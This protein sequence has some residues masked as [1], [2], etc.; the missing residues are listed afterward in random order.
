MGSFK[1][2]SKFR[3]VAEV[4]NMCIPNEKL[5]LLLNR[6]IQKLHLRNVRLFSEE[7]EEQ[8]KRYVFN[9]E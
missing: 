4:V 8:L 1:I 6:V 7:E 3:K 2:A 5:P 9:I